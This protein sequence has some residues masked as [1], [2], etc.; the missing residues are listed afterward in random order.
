PGAG[1][2]DRD[3]VLGGVAD[4]QRQEQHLGQPGPHGLDDRLAAAPGHVHVEQHD[5]GARGPDAL[6]G[7]LHVDRV[8][9]YLAAYVLAPGQLDPHARPEQ[10]VVV[11]E[12]DPDGPGGGP[13][14]AARRRHDAS[15]RPRAT[16]RLTSVP[17]PGALCTS[18]APP[19]RAIR[20]TID[21]AMPR[22]SPS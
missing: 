13:G 21:S 15:A 22:R 19:W 18:A 8:A 14:P 16:R 9:D 4:R 6:D 5:V 3:D 1:P 11:D 2:D 10:P 7:R 20:L 17:S 12:E